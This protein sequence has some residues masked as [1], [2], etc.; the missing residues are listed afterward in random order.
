[1]TP[2]LT[3]PTSIPLA[4]LDLSS[5]CLKGLKAQSLVSKSKNLRQLKDATFYNSPGYSLTPALG[6]ML[7][8]PNHVTSEDLLMM[9]RS[10]QVY[11]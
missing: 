5:S 6:L 11:L 10:F 4:D 7:R 1:M 8:F 3:L 9:K 2:H